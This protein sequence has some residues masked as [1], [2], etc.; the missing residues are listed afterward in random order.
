[1]PTLLLSGA[2]RGIGLEYA[3]QYLADGWRV[4]ACCR[5]P[6]RAKELKSLEGDLQVHK[7]DVT[8]AL[9]V[10]NLARELREEP[11]D[12][13]INNA[14]V[15]GARSGFG[16][17]DFD[18]WTETLQINLLGPLRVVEAFL[19]LLE[20]AEKPCIVNMSSRLGSIGLNQGGGSYPYRT[21]KAALNMVTKNLSVDLAD[22]GVIVISVHPGWVETDMGGASAP[23][24]VEDSVSGL[25]TLIG[26][27]EPG[28]SGGF[29]TYEGEE[30]PW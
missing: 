2:N 11:L 18:A 21:S 14:G 15:Y 13:L 16:S 9:Q 23:V 8:D 5:F 28:Q 29:F 12:L 20:K 3:R 10:A 30:L 26:A 19:P 22:K 4:H 6:D 7:M 1:M 24:S 17:Q 25:R 27:L